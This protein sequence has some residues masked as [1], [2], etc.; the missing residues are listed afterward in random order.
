M[1]ALW[2]TEWL[3]IKSPIVWLSAAWIGVLVHGDWH[4]GRPGPSHLSFGLPYHWLLAVFAFAPLPW[5]LIRRWP[6]SLAQ[7]SILVIAVGVALGQGLEPLGEVIH[8]HV[9]AE[10]FTNP[11]R[12]RIFAEFMVAGILA[13][14]SSAAIAAKRAKRGAA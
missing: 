4:L 11:L 3:V 1:I 7:V 8:F 2:E 6:N 13:Y 10:P 5:I 14:L 12:W 9:G